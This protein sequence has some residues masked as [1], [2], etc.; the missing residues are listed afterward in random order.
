MV[1]AFID[2]GDDGRLSA[3]LARTAAEWKKRR[4]TMSSSGVL[5]ACTPTM[6][7]MVPQ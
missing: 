4:P 7:H 5:S 3:I 2:D 6:S 1:S